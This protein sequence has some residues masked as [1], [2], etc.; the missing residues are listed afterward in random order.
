MKSPIGTSMYALIEELWP[1]NRSLTGNGVRETL[2]RIQ[3]HIE[4]VIREVPTGTPV[5]D[6]TVPQEWNVR[7][8][9]IKNDRGERVVDWQQSN[10]HVVGYSQP[11]QK[12][13]TLAELTPHL[14]SLPN[15]PDWIPYRTAYYEKSWGFCLRHSEL[16]TLPAGDYEV[17]IDADLS[18]GHLTYGEYVI[19]GE[20]ADEVL[21]S[22]HI[23]HPSMANDN[24]SGV[25]LAVFLAKHIATIKPR[26]TYRFLFIPGTIGSITW[27]AGHEEIIP[28]IKHGLVLTG[29]GDAGKLHYKRSRRGDAEIDRAA[30]NVLKHSGVEH[31]VR[32]FSP[33]GYDERQYCSPG[34]N[35]PVGSLTRTPHGEYLEYHTSGDDLSFVHPVFLEEAYAVCQQLLAVLEGNAL[36]RNQFPFGEPQLGKRGLYSAMGAASGEVKKKQLAMLWV[37]NMSDGSNSLL[38][39]SD[40]SGLPFH[41]IRQMADLLLAHGILQ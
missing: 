24:L 27:L 12:T 8:A 33:F 23:C 15:H 34:F 18:D 10:L 21:I 4:V 30:T 9:Y 36:Y 7:D 28:R 22:T 3:K 37:L 41:E 6:W 35:L 16:T 19:P 39:I 1:L 13:M 20:T 32:E 17:C 38:D 14:F 26:Y 40:R 29:V 11:I 25:A 2:A 31:A 5:F